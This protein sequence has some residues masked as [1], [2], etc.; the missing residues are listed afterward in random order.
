MEDRSLVSVQWIDV[1]GEV[2]VHQATTG[3]RVNMIHHRSI[4]IVVLIKL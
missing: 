4:E 3:V 2:F 1:R